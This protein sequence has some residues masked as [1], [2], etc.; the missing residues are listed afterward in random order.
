MRLHQSARLRAGEDREERIT[1]LLVTAGLVHPAALRNRGSYDVLQGGLDD[2][3][4]DAE[5]RR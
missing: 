2:E 3:A 5:D 1:N 4:Q